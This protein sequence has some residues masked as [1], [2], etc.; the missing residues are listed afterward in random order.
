[1]A[2]ST[3]R[4][5]PRDGPRR[6]IAQR[7][8]RGAATSSSTAGSSPRSAHRTARCRASTRRGEATPAPR[9]RSAWSTARSR[10]PARPTATRSSSRPRRSPDSRLDYL[11]LGHWHSTQQG[12][13]GRRH[14]R[15]RR[16]PRAGRARPGSGRQGPPRRARRT[17]TASARVTIEERQ[18]GRTTFER[19]ELDAATID[20]QPALID[21]TGQAGR[22]RPRPRRPDRRRPPG[23]ARPRHRRDRD[24]A[25]PVVPQ[26]PGPRRVAARPD[27]GHAAVARHDRGRVHPRPRGADRRAR[28]GRQG[29]RGRRAARLRCASAGCCWPAT[30]S[31]CEDPQARAPRLPPLPRPRHRPRA[32]PDRRPR[33]E[34]G[35]QDDDPAGDR[36]RPHPPG[37]EH[38]PATST[39]S[40]RGTRRR[41]RAL[42]H[43]RSSSSRTTRT[44]PKVGHARED[45]R[46]ARRARSASTTT[47]SRSPT[48]PSPTRSWPS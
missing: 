11:A 26:G 43:H 22:S 29:R 14:L 17:P 1:M 3:D 12:Q 37:D 9:G 32:R 24:G 7:P 33:P 6:R 45:L 23:R 2:G 25:R 21:G 34:R 44:A 10:S 39:P 15:V 46:A 35:R 16:R 5:R 13:A 41:G 30:R 20:S 42:D 18:V 31:R 47:A 27:R 19:V 38:R 4:R 8:P 36:A 48:R 28:G 40:A